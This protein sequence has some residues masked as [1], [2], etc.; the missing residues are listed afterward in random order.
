VKTRVSLVTRHNTGN[1]V[2]IFALA[3]SPKKSV[4]KAVRSGGRKKY[5]S[6]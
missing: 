2:Q 5:F 6:P 3:A 4:F 1:L